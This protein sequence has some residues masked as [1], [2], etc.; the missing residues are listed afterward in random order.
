MPFHTGRERPEPKTERIIMMDAKMLGGIHFFSGLT[1]GDLKLISGIC[2]LVT[3]KKGAKIFSR[4]DSAKN[5]YI[6]HSGKVHLSFQIPILLADGEIVVEMIRAGDIFGWSALVEPHKFTLSAY[7]DSDSE[8]IE[9]G[10]KHMISMC[11]KRPRV[12][13]ILIGNL[14][15]VLGSRMDRMQLLIEK[16]IG[17]NVPSFE[18]RRAR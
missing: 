17:L 16:E 15:K 12:G 2:K 3:L 1:A 14:A 11:A 4:G 9:I 8:L 7:C 18:G 10:G 13:Y 6:V 5:F